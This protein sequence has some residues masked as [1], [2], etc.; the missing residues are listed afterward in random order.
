MLIFLPPVITPGSSGIRNA[1][2]RVSEGVIRHLSQHS[3]LAG[4]SRQASPSSLNGL[5][6]PGAIAST[7]VAPGIIAEDRSEEVEHV[8]SGALAYEPST[9]RPQYS[10]AYPEP[11]GDVTLDDAL[12][13]GEHPF[14]DLL[15]RP[16]G[17]YTGGQWDEA[18]DSVL[19]QMVP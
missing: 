13:F 19:G 14:D 17:D 8:A 7:S 11:L 15:F 1:F 9:T 3:R 16:L 4:L 6:Q 10:S 18:V 5:R 12:M 2:E